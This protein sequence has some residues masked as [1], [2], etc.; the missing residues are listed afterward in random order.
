MDRQGMTFVL[1]HK[2]TLMINVLCYKF[3]LMI[4]VLCFKFT[5]M[6]YLWV[7]IKIRKKKRIHVFLSNL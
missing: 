7:Q 6:I 2:F 5:L 4:N 1:C 3:T